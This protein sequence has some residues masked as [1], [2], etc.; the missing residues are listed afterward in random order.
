M[1]DNQLPPIASIELAYLYSQ[2]KPRV[3]LHDVIQCTSHCGV[4]VIRNSKLPVLNYKTSV[5]S[6][7]NI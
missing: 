4:C 3:K 2:A 6:V 1:Q 7:L 5:M